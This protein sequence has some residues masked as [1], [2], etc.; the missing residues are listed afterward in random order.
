MPAWRSRCAAARPE[1]PA[2][3][4]AHRNAVPTS[5]VAQLGR[6]GSVPSSASSSVKK[7]SQCSS[8][9]RPTRNAKSRR[10]SSAVSMWSGRPAPAW[11]A[12]AATAAAR[13][14]ASCSSVSPRPGTRSWVWSGAHASASSERSPV[15]WATAQRSGC[16]SAAANAACNRV[17]SSSAPVASAS[18]PPMG[19]SLRSPTRCRRQRPMCLPSSAIWLLTSTV[20]GSL[21]MATARLSAVQRSS[22][23]TESAMDQPA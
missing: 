20:R 19:T 13:A 11:N 16:T 10:R 4:T 5:A 22:V 14:A 1:A 7:P 17:A 23:S 15:L 6:R 18:A 8:T 2:P 3:T 12:R 9:P 21:S